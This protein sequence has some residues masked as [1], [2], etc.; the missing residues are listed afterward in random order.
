MFV[1]RNILVKKY[2][3]AVEIGSVV[4]GHFK[5]SP[6]AYWHANFLGISLEGIKGTGPKGHILK[7][8]ILKMTKTIETIETG[9]FIDFSFLVEVPS[10]PSDEIIKKCVESIKKLSLS[11][12][13]INYKSLPE[14]GLIQF[15]LKMKRRPSPPET[16]NIK[17]LLKIYLNDSIHLLL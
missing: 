1:L 6:A 2:S 15:E 17:N 10:I 13:E 11:Q 5:V 3:K 9:N 12:K 4:K 16:E 8:D 7:S 14:I